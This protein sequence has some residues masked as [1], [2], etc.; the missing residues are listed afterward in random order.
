METGKQEYWTAVFRREQLLEL[1]EGRGP[2]PKNDNRLTAVRHCGKTDLV[3]IWTTARAKAFSPLPQVIVGTDECLG[4]L[5]A[6][7]GTYLRELGLISGL[8]RTMSLA[9]FDSALTRSPPKE[10]WEIAG[11]AVGI[12]IGEVW[13]RS[14]S[15]ITLEEAATA[16]PNST[17]SYAMMRSWA[18]GYRTEH[19][20]EVFDKY[21][22]VAQILGHPLQENIARSVLDVVGTVVGAGGYEEDEKARISV[23]SG[24]WE[25]LRG[26]VNVYEVLP[27][28]LRYPKDLFGARDI[29]G[30]KGKTA[31]ERVQFFDVLAPMLAKESEESGDRGAAFALALS[32]FVCRPGFFQQATLLREYAERLPE[33]ILWLGAFQMLSPLADTLLLQSGAGWRIARELDRPGDV[34]SVPNAEACMAEVEKLSLAKSR[35][36]RSLFEKPRVDVEIYPMIVSTFR[37]MKEGPAARAQSEREY[38]EN[39]LMENRTYLEKLSL[40]EVRLHEA[41][42][43]VQDAQNADTGKNGR[44][45]RGRK[46]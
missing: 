35:A 45:G 18:L 3:G 5:F 38:V 33:A 24:W 34:F 29:E 8:V 11:A 41:L 16:T 27:E 13:C 44:R 30:I 39:I 9:Q 7:S 23:V 14:G 28:V 6:W 19:S 22:K 37:G 4:D 25:L 31:E 10:L 2:W 12:V 32:A 43:M 20:R 46:R 17:L 21:G 26:N 1:L 15:R 42:H 40:L 36:Y